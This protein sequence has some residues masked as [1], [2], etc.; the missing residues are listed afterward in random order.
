MVIFL[1]E[2]DSTLSISWAWDQ[3]LLAEKKEEKVLFGLVC[4]QPA[5]GMVR[6]GGT[7]AACDGP[8]RAISS[9]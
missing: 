6:N 4:S 8:A 3:G 7:K 9:L 1:V 2:M 5:L